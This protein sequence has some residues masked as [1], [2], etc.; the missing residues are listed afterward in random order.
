MYNY[1]RVHLGSSLLA[2][3]ATRSADRGVPLSPPLV[4]GGEGLEIGPFLN[5]QVAACVVK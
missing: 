1:V 3:N 4:I 2:E 5:S